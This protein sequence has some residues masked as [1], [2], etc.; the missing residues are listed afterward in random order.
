MAVGIHHGFSDTDLGSVQRVIGNS[1]HAAVQGMAKVTKPTVPGRRDRRERGRQM[2]GALWVYL[3]RFLGFLAWSNRLL[4]GARCWRTVTADP[5]SAER[6]VRQQ[7]N[8]LLHQKAGRQPGIPGLRSGILWFLYSAYWLETPG[9]AAEGRGR[10]TGDYRPR[11]LQSRGHR[12]AVNSPLLCQV[13]LELS[14]EAGLTR[15]LPARFSWRMLKL[16][17]TGDH[18]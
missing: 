14:D 4:R 15:P 8:L 11:L 10:W 3:R 16:L 18:P 7:W 1:E 12:T 6:G 9:A 5:E 17:R 2:R 13:S